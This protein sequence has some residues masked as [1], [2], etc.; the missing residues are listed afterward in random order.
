MVDEFLIFYTNYKTVELVLNVR[1]KEPFEVYDN[2]LIR[3]VMDRFI[4]YGNVRVVFYI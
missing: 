3:K 1:S 2:M 4:N